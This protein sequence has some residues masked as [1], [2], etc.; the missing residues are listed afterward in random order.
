MLKIFIV[1]DHPMLRDGLRHL[2]S[3]QESRGRVC[4]EA[5]TAAEA[6]S[7]LADS[8]A[9]I[10]LMD[11][12]LPDRSGLEVIRDLHAM[13]PELPVLVLSM[14]DEM[15]Y[16]ERVIR[17]GGKGYLV[18]GASA[19]E[20]RRAVEEVISG[21]IYLSDR[22]SKHV[23]QGLAKGKSGGLASG[24]QRLSDRELEVFELLGHGLSTAEIGGKLQISPRTVDAHRSNI[25]TKLGLPDSL[26][27]IREAV[28]WVEVGS[29]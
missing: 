21:A 3:Q 19:E 13:R 6:I 1:D 16:A 24:L 11:L 14:H 18:K 29:G 12:T 4:G 22:A 8:D 5:A 15:L 7:A 23:L 9:D 2:F 26:A 20:I 17:A 28:I 27:V 10:V 25:R